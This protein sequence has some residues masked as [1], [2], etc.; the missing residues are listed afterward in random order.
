[1]TGGDPGH[2]IDLLGLR[3]EISY[4]KLS[5][6]EE[7]Q[8]LYYVNSMFHRSS[9]YERQAD[10]EDYEQIMLS[11]DSLPD[12][13]QRSIPLSVTIGIS[14]LDNE[15]TFSARSMEFPQAELNI[16]AHYPNDEQIITGTTIDRSG[17][18]GT[19][20][21]QR[22]SGT[23]RKTVNP[24]VF[25]PP[26]GLETD[27][28]VKKIWSELLRRR[29]ESYAIQ[30]LQIVD[31]SIRQITLTSD[32]EYRCDIL[33]DRTAGPRI[34]ISELGGGTY[35]LFSLGCALAYSSNGTLL[36]DEIDTG[37]HY[38]RMADMWKMVIEASRE[39][40]VQVFATTHSQDCIRALAECMAAQP[41]YEPE[42]A[43]LRIDRTTS[44]AV[45]F[46]GEE[47]RVVVDHEIEV[48]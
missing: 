32:A 18:I 10:L 42:T 4:G 27:V 7:L 46:A 13:G 34:K 2:L 45:R 40:N 37:L 1:V 48:R 43:I 11:G 9:S 38:S 31:D 3:E 22:F 44:E 19:R 8:T 6:T 20:L 26:G 23:R 5:R 14:E 39:L 41:D 15:S 24:T 36:L 28:I 17:R 21:E 25:V 33:I 29:Q 47:L 35:S 12:E 30:S 16:T